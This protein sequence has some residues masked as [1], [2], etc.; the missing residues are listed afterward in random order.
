MNKH[1]VKVSI[2]IPTKNAS[3]EFDI[4][5]K[6]IFEQN[7]NKK[8]EVIIIDS[9]STD[10][11]IEI[12]K[13]YPVRLI[14][15]KPKEFGHGKT[16]N[17]GA[18]L[19]KGEYLVYLTHDAIPVNNNWLKNLITNLRDK[20]VAGVYSKQIPKNNA[21]I[22]VKF[23]L[24]KTYPDYKIKKSLKTLKSLTRS[25][26]FFSNVSS[27]IKKDIWNSYKFNES[28]LLGE[29]QAWSKTV[30]LNGYSIIYEPKAKVYHSHNYN[31]VDTFK[32]YF[33][34]GFS[35]K[36]RATDKIISISKE[37]LY[38]LKEE[39]IFLIK[40]NLWYKIP[41]MFIYEFSRYCGLLLGYNSNLIPKFI[42]RSISHHKYY[43]KN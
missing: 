5:L 30:L 32:R 43:W 21:N 8:F 9:G 29:D 42:K 19:S 6:R 13:K 39:I 26:M 40:N 38:F 23:Y 20:N 36:Q 12:A 1:R 25:E 3:S 37:G 2:I 28:V 27:A 41:H 4:V 7:F 11:T 34:H 35:L 10:E 31:I 22:F 14:Q 17:Y 24:S 15:I 33:D 16:R 18:E